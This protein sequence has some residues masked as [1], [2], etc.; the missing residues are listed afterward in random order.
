MK[1]DKNIK[2]RKYNKNEFIKY[3]KKINVS[4]DVIK[5][6]T[7]LPNQVTYKNDTYDLFIYKVWYNKHETYH[8]FELNYY[9]SDLN[10]FLV[11]YKNFYDIKI[12]VSYLFFKLKDLD[13]L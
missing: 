8:S 3:L 5:L 9:S 7:Q 11:P 2:P 4:N 12:S 10:E 6:F 1:V 13:I